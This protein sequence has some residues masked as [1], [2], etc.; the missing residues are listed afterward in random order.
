MIHTR[1]SS[2]VWARVR[3]KRGPGL[4]VWGRKSAIML[5]LPAKGFFQSWWT[6]RLEPRD[7]AGPRAHLFPD[8]GSRG[9]RG[10]VAMSPGTGRCHCTATM[11]N[12]QRQVETCLVRFASRACPI[13]RVGRLNAF[14][15]GGVGSGSPWTRTRHMVSWVPGAVP[16]HVSVGARSGEPVVVSRLPA[17]PT[18]P[19][20]GS[21]RGGG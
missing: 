16:T 19:R 8:P 15:L 18:A 14:V 10:T 6:N 4:A 9:A 17:R 21:R 13:D 3:S 7:G 11:A 2:L 12:R 20:A 1:P 5:D